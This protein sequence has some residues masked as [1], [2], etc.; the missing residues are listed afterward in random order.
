M[1]MDAYPGTLKYANLNN[2]AISSGLGVIS[3]ALILS[4]GPNCSVDRLLLNRKRL[5]FIVH[6]HTLFF[7]HCVVR[8]ICFTKIYEDTRSVE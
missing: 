8:R 6:G 1:E 4:V 2:N 3:M 7:E 5:S